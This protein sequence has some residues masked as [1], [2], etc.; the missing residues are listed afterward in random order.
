M[1]A[2]ECGDTLQASW[3]Q[4]PILVTTFSA[5]LRYLTS[6]TRPLHHT[7]APDPSSFNAR[8]AEGHTSVARKVCSRRT[9]CNGFQPSCGGVLILDPACL[10][11]GQP[12]RP[13]SQSWWSLDP[14]R[15]LFRP[16]LCAVA[17]GCR[18]LSRP[19]A[20]LITRIGSNLALEAAAR[21][22]TYAIPDSSVCPA[23]RF[24]CEAL[25]SSGMRSGRW[26]EGRS[27]R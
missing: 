24:A 6:C 12:G 13:F 21:L 17:L 18:R 26:W 10:T 8:R 14:E 16:P 19:Q 4:V 1:K 7:H 11:L 23:A 20:R 5:K 15:F 3:R 25:L 9:V 2:S 27:R 22:L